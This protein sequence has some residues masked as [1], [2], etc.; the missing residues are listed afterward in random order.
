MEG[1][2]VSDLF[3]ALL[4]D[5][6]NTQIKYVMAN[7]ISDLS[8]VKRCPDFEDLISHISLVSEVLVSSV[9]HLSLLVEL[10]RLC[11]RFNK[12]CKII[13]TEAETLDIQCAYE[14]FQTLGV[15]RWL[16]IL[17]AREITQ[18]PVA[19]IDLGTANTCD[20]VVNNKH[21]GGWIAPGF[22]IMRESLLS[23]TQQ[24]FADNSLPHI[25]DIG[26]TTE[27]C[28]S[29]GCLASQAGFVMIAEQYLNNKY[30]DYFVLVT[31]G[32]QHSL[33]LKDNKKILSFPNLVLRG[34]FRLI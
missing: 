10:E 16:A 25:L 7:D 22:S 19:V 11:E 6:G 3:K 28:V 20:I 12:P 17:A 21:M 13:H 8:D 32:G 24:V 23:N 15:D 5:I 14:K 9:G 33:N 29:Y 34:L 27:N 1:K 4:I 2:S 18:L 26:D 30:E 31:G